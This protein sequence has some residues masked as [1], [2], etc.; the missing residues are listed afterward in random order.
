MISLLRA[1]L[2]NLE[3]TK[4]GSLQEQGASPYCSLSIHIL[5]NKCTHLLT[6]RV[7][8]LAGIR[9]VVCGANSDNTISQLQQTRNKQTSPQNTVALNDLLDVRINTY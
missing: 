1:F 2:H 5:S 4:W 8:V 3:G 6:A 7:S 9:T